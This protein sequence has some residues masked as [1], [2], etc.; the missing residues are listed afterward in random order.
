MRETPWKEGVFL[1]RGR[2]ER[3]GRGGKARA[4]VKSARGGGDIACAGCAALGLAF[5]WDPT[6]EITST[7]NIVVTG[8]SDAFIALEGWRVKNVEV[9]ESTGEFLIVEITAS[10]DVV[11][12][13]NVGEAEFWR[14]SAGGE[15]EVVDNTGAGDG[16]PADFT[17]VGNSTRKD[18]VFSGNVGTSY[19][20]T[21]VAGKS[22]ECFGN[23]P[24]PTGW[25]NAAGKDVEGQCAALTGPSPE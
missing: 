22:L 13:E 23:D 17:L 6:F 7:R 3:D 24:A 15:L 14:V 18:L 5:M 16:F 20:E 2:C 10:G 12:A 9:R 21:N 1:F 8:A 4:G 19:L 25:G 11:F